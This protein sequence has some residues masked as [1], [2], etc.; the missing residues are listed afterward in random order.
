MRCIFASNK[1][2]KTMAV[3]IF[4]GLIMDVLDELFGKR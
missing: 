1:N 4:I 2:R 3:I